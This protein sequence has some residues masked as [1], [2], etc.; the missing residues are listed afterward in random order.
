MDLDIIFYDDWIVDLESLEIPHKDMQNRKFV[1]EPLA[2][3]APFYRHPLT[4]KT[5]QQMLEELK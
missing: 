4:K 3:L 2:E 1:L 5:V